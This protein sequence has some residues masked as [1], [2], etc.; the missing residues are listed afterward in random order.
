[1]DES[2]KLKITGVALEILSPL[3]PL[4]FSIAET[5]TKAS[6]DVTESFRFQLGTTF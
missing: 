2:N 1:M 5:I 3:G 4:S 6:T